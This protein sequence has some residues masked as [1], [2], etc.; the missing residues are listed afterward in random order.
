M[1][2]LVVQLPRDEGQNA[3]QTLSPFEFVCTS[4]DDNKYW[5]VTHNIRVIDSAGGV[6]T[7]AGGSKSKDAG[8]GTALWRADSES[9]PVR[10]TSDA[11]SQVKRNHVGGTNDVEQTTR[12]VVLPNRH[13]DTVR[14][15]HH[16]HTYSHMFGTVQLFR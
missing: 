11:I 8:G 7:E 5:K 13:H 16:T 15:P 1:F 3:P 9:Y 12:P 6:G 4:D 2:H 10:L 14:I